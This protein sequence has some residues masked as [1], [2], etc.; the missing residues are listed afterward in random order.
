MADLPEIW[1]EI[2][3]VSLG[4]MMPH[5]SFND[6][7]ASHVTTTPPAYASR[8]EVAVREAASISR[9]MHM[10]HPPH[11]AFV[12]TA[13]INAQYRSGNDTIYI[14]KGD[15]KRLTPDNIKGLVEHESGHR[16]YFQKKHHEILFP[17]AMEMDAD[18][19]GAIASC[20]PER[21]ENTLRATGALTTDVSSQRDYIISRADPLLEPY[22]K[23]LPDFA[24]NAITNIMTAGGLANKLSMSAQRG[25]NN[26]S[27]NDHPVTE[28]RI[29][30]LERIKANL[31]PSC[32]SRSR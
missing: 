9:A 22:L 15:L 20:K 2:L 16:E 28:D 13:I 25:L 32:K 6:Y 24:V 10:N 27:L 19:R 29:E 18:T 12:D 31:P 17:Q 5:N 23:K 30:N 3:R 7:I 21:L 1:K 26:I 8:M 4:A 14:T 11:V